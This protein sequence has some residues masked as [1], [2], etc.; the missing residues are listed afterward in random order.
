[1]S[2]A[3]RVHL[4]ETEKIKGNEYMAVKEFKFAL[5]KYNKSLELNPAEPTTFSNR[6]LC[7]FKL[8]RKSISRV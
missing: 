3:E 2:E 7:F 6:G 4:A 5:E 1:M 8:S